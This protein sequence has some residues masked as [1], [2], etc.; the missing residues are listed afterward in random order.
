LCL[1]VNM[2]G[3]LLHPHNTHHLPSLQTNPFSKKSDIKF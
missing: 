3:C 1:D 2:G